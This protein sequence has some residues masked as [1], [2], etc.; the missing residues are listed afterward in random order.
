MR[1]YSLYSETIDEML[2]QERQRL[3]QEQLQQELDA[4]QRQHQEELRR[5]QII[6]QERQRLLAAHA[7][8]LAGYL[9]KRAFKSAE[10]RRQFMPA[11][12]SPCGQ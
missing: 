5:L 1:R 6:E 7:Q 12:G 10:E 2:V 4:Q 11:P 3:F 8:E 9:P